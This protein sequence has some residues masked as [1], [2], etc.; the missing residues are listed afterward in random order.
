MRSFTDY[1][2]GCGLVAEMFGRCAVTAFLIPQ[3]EQVIQRMVDNGWAK[4]TINLRI[5]AVK[6]MFH[7]A[8][9]RDLIT[10]EQYAKIRGV[11]RI[12]ADDPRVKPP[13]AVQP[14]PVD[15]VERT[16]PYFP[17]II[18]D[19]VQVQLKAGM[20]AAEVCQMRFDALHWDADG[21]LW[22]RPAKHKTASK[23]KKRNILLGP[24]SQAIL[25]KYGIEPNTPFPVD[26]EYVFD[27]RPSNRQ[28][29]S[30]AIPYYETDRYTHEIRSGV[31]R[32]IAAGSITAEERWTSHQL[33]HRAGTDARREFELDAAQLLLGHSDVRTTE[34]YAEPDLSKAVDFAKRCG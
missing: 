12:K 24:H 30:K 20:R 9:M 16:L 3:F 33:R 2:K 29:R 25:Q 31:E 22:Y 14:V 1:K 5:G 19:I 10:G 26:S 4:R 27:P 34:R 15:V 32:A 6:Q 18:A 17:P 13:R 8:M 21:I 28:A 7:H 11:P 23:G